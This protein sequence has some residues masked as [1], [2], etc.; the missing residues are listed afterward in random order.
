MII[1]SNKIIGLIGRLLIPMGQLS[2]LRISVFA[3]AILMLF[4]TV[5]NKF[6][7]IGIAVAQP[8]TISEIEVEGNTRIEA[9]T[10]ETYLTIQRDLPFTDSD[11]DDSLKEMFATGLFTD[12]GIERRGETLVVTVSENAL[13]R[14]ISFEGNSRITDDALQEVIQSEERE[15]L[16]QTRVQ[17]D[18][19]LI[20]E[21]YR[22]IGRYRAAVEPKYIELE[23]N[24]VDL[25]FEINEGTKTKIERITFIGNRNYSD[26]NLRDVIQTREAGILSFL[27]TSDVYDP[28]RFDADQELLRR[29]YFQQGYADFRIVSAIADLDR[30]QNL[31]YLTITIDEGVKYEYGN[32]DID[33]TLISVDPR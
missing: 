6:S 27:R 7:N 10:I 28:D 26:G 11:I 3:V 2:W 9:E 14:E 1:D 25:V 22:R 30:E 17:G 33:T 8:Y 12:V 20:L 15:V 13:I 5:T 31:F 21:S 4:G 29:F 16:T 19:Q 23:N 18:L 32:I 24:R